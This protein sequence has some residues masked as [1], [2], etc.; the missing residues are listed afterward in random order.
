MPDKSHVSMEQHVCTVCGKQYDTGAIL[1]DKRLRKSL[2]PKTLTGWGMCP[3]HQAKYDEGYIALVECD[4]S[5]SGAF[6]GSETIRR[7]DVWRTGPVIH[8]RKAVFE[9]V[10]SGVSSTQPDGSMLPVCWIE[11]DVT[12]QLEQL[13]ATAK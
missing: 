12:K 13:A 7:E 8:M 9:Q 2:G 4:R 5:K 1:L 6:S 10:F 3:E 11:P